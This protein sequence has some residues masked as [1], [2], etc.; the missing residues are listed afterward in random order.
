MGSTYYVAPGGSDSNP[1]TQ[2]SPFATIQRGVNLAKPGDTVSVADGTYGP[3]GHYTC[4]NTCSQNGFASPVVFTKSGAP[5]APITVAAQNRWGAVLDCQ[6]P[7]G[8]SGDGTDGVQA[9][10][11][12]FDFKATASWI[13]VKNFDVTRAYWSG[14]NVNERNSNITFIG[15]HF[16]HIGNRIYTVASGTGYGIT[17][18]FAGTESSNV[19]WDSNEFSNIGRLPTPGKV[20]ADDYSHDHGIYVFNG[21]YT[22]TNNI[23]YANTA[24]WGLQISPGTHDTAVINNTFEGANPQQDGLLMLWGNS[25]NITIQNNIFYGARNYAIANWQAAASGATIDHNLVY[26]SPRGIINTGAIAGVLT[27]L[28]NLTNRDPLFVNMGGADFHLQAASPAIDSGSW[29]NVAADLDGN[30]RPSGSA[31]DIGAYEYTAYAAPPAPPTPPV[32]PAQSL[33]A[34]YLSDLTPAYAFQSWGTPQDDTSIIGFP[35]SLNGIRYSKGLGVHAYSDLR[36]PLWNNCTTFTATVG[37]DDEIPPG[38]G[39]LAFQVWADDIKLYDSGTL[40]SGSP[41][42]SVNVD[43][44]GRSTLALIVTNGIFQAPAWAVPVDHADW[45]NASISCRN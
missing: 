45:A 9:C 43:L 5:G 32:P 22:I 33:V 18:V 1:G 38:M 23:F 6:L 10:D 31:F 34:R 30:P 12:Y 40:Q 7:A 4:G 2:S 16:H 26:G 14:A 37:V 8:Y 24:G 41:A 39:S 17:G 36:Y 21:P 44:T 35:I 27:L 42:R 13:T 11:S 29:E 15:N 28:A 20:V 19:T 3:N 25:S